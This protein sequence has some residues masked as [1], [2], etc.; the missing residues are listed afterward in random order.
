AKWPANTGATM[1]DGFQQKKNRLDSL[2]SRIA[3]GNA[4]ARATTRDD[5]R[6]CKGCAS[7][8]APNTVGDSC[9]TCSSPAASNSS[10]GPTHSTKKCCPVCGLGVLTVSS[11][12]TCGV[13]RKWI[14]AE[15]DRSIESDPDDYTCAACRQSPI[16]GN[17]AMLGVA[18]VDSPLADAEASNQG[19]IQ[20]GVGSLLG[21]MRS[22]SVAGSIGGE[23]GRFSQRERRMSGS[24]ESSSYS[25]RNS[26]SFDPNA[27]SED[28]DEFR[29][30]SGRGGSSSRGGR[31]GKKKPGGRGGTLMKTRSGGKPPSGVFLDRLGKTERG[32][33]GK[34]RGAGK[35]AG[36]SS[37]KGS[38]AGSRGGGVRRTS[39]SGRGGGV[40]G[41]VSQQVNNM[42]LAAAA[43]GNNQIFTAL[44][45]YQHA[46][47]MQAGKPAKTSDEAPCSSAAIDSGRG[48][49][50]DEYTRTV[51]IEKED[52]GFFSSAPLCL[53]CGSIGVRAEQSM[54]ACS[55]CAHSFH[56]YCVGLHEKMNTTIKDR[57]WRCLD[58]TICEGCGTNTDESKLIMCEECDVAYHMYCLNPPLERAPPGPWR[59]QWCAKC[60][61]CNM[62]VANSGEL[63]KEGLCYPCL[64][65]R[66]C[67]KCNKLYQLNENI[68]RCSQCFKWYHGACEDLHNEEMLENAAL[69]KMRCSTCRP[70]SG[71]GLSSM[72]DGNI[73]ICDNVALNKCADEVLKSKMMPQLF[74]ANS[75]TD[76]AGGTSALAGLLG[77]FRSGGSIDSHYGSMDDDGPDEDGMGGGLSSLINFGPGSRGGRGGGR[78][79]GAGRG[80]LLKMGVG[81]FFVKQ[82]KSKQPVVE[83]NENGEI[84]PN[85]LTKKVKM[86]RKPRRSQL[87][88]FYPSQIQEA[89][90]GIRPVDGK[91]L[92]DIEVP[93]PVME[94]YRAPRTVTDPFQMGFKLSAAATESLRRDIEEN[95]MLDNLNLNEM[96]NPDEDF[97]FD[98]WLDDEDDDL[99][100]A[101]DFMKDDTESSQP[102]PEPD[103]G[104]G[105]QMPPQPGHHQMQQQQH[106]MGMPTGFG[107][108]GG[109]MIKLEPGLM[110]P[111]QMM[112]HPH[113]MMGPGGM[114]IKQEPGM[115]RPESSMSG[116]SLMAAP[117]GAAHAGER[118]S[119][120]QAAT[121]RWEEDEPL[122]DKA[123]K[124]AVLYVNINF[125]NQRRDMPDW[126][127]RAKFI[128]KTWRSLSSDDRQIYVQKA[129]HNR[130]QREKV[131]RPR[132][133]RNPQLGAPGPSGIPTTGQV[134]MR[135]A[136]GAGAMPPGSF[137][138]QAAM[139]NARPPMPP[140]ITQQPPSVSHLP[141][142]LQQQYESMRKA[143]TE[144]N[145]K[146]EALAKELAA[147][148]TTKKKLGAKLR[149]IQ[150]VE[151]AK[152]LAQAVAAAQ[153]AGIEPPTE[154]PQTGAL[155]QMERETY[156]KAI[157]QTPL[158]VKELDDAKRIAKA[159]LQAMHSFEANHRIMS[160]HV[161]AQQ[162][163][164]A[165]SGGS[166]G[167]T[168]GGM[169]SASMGGRPGMGMT[170]AGPHGF[171]QM[172]PPQHVPFSQMMGQ[173]RSFQLGGLGSGGGGGGMMGSRMGP[174]ASSRW[175]PAL[176]RSSVLGSVRYDQIQT[177]E[178]RD[179]YECLDE[180]I[181]KISYDFDGPPPMMQQQQQM[182]GFPGGGNSLKR[183]LD[184]MAPP[185]MGMN[186]MMQGD[187]GAPKQ[188]K[189]RQM[190]KKTTNPREGQDYDTCLQRMKDA[191]AACPPLTRKAI[192][193]VA[194][195]ESSPFNWP[196][197]SELD[198]IPESNC[199]LGKLT[200]PFALD[201]Y[202]N[203]RHVPPPSEVSMA[204]LMP[205][206]RMSLL[207]QMAGA[208]SCSSPCTP[209]LV[210]DEG[211]ISSPSTSHGAANVSNAA[212]AASDVIR[213]LVNGVEKKR[214]VLRCLAKANESSFPPTDPH[215]IA[216][217]ESK[218]EDDEEI[219][220]AIEIEERCAPGPSGMGGESSSAN[221]TSSQACRDEITKDLLQK[222]QKML[223]TKKPIDDYQM[224]TPPQS[225]TGVD[226]HMDVKP[227]PLGFLSHR[228]R[229]CAN[230][231]SGGAIATAYR[232]S[233]SLLGLTP[234][235][236][237]KDDSVT[238]CT[239]KCYYS[240]V[241]NAKVALSPGQLDA[242]QDHVDDLTYSRLKQISADSFAR[243]INQ[244]SM[245]GVKPET[246][247]GVAIA[248]QLGT[249]GAAG[250]VG[251]MGGRGPMAPPGPPPPTPLGGGTPDVT[252]PRENKFG[253]L[254]DDPPP[255][256][257]NIHVI[258]CSDLA[259]LDDSSRKERARAAGEDWK[260]YDQEI[261]NS[262]IRIRMFKNELAMQPKMGIDFAN[263]P[264][265]TRKCALC[266]QKGDTDPTQGGRLLNYD[267]GVWIHAN[268]TLWCPEVYETPNGALL[269]V[270]KALFRANY[271]TCCLC[272]LTGPTLQ[273][274]K[275]ECQ[276]YFHFGCANRIRGKFLKDKTFICPNH[277]DVN[278]D[279]GANIEPLRKL[280]IPRDENKLLTKLFEHVDG[281]RLMLRLGAFTFLRLGQLL[282][283]QLK[284]CHSSRFIF[285]LGYSAHRMYWS[286]F[287][288][289]KRVK[290]SL[291]ITEHEGK[292]LF[293]VS[294]PPLRDEIVGAAIQGQP[295][296]A[297]PH[298]W[299]KASAGEAWKEV[300]DCVNRVRLRSGSFLR[301]PGHS[302]EGES[303]FGLAEGVITKMTESLPGVDTLYSYTFRH[304]GAP[305]LELP[306]AENPSGCARCE[307]RL[308]TLIKSHRRPVPSGAKA[309]SS[310][311][312]RGSKRTPSL[313]EELQMYAKAS[314]YKGD[315]VKNGKWE[316]NGTN[317]Q[318]YSA[319]QKMR[320]EWRNTVY[321]ARSAIQGLGL[322][323]KQDI[324]MD[325]MIIEYKGEV[326]RGEV[327]EMREKKYFAQNRGTYMFKA[328][329]ECIIDAT[330]KGGP[331]RYINHS[332]DPN[333]RTKIMNLGPNGEE[334][335]IIIIAARPIKA[336]EELTYDY[337]FDVED[338]SEKVACLCG[339][340]NCQRW[341]N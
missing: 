148:R 110:H 201:V 206:V 239:L 115:M 326:V 65:L 274:Y 185:L 76:S 242:A 113:A 328:S 190:Q 275:M 108:P 21:S 69:N 286:P 215:R 96:M 177:T 226:H 243:S 269:N 122:G 170:L 27:C 99:N 93:E 32:K 114:M 264:H 88:D 63:T 252:S 123:T 285:P 151:T 92:A 70:N 340:P 248:Q 101:L 104:M 144:Y 256:K 24:S 141:P 199:G 209:L 281:P 61:R 267:V 103:D 125:P 255:R 192:E 299:R 186:S 121:E 152:A 254:M 13:C 174:M 163:A 154:V 250:L 112:Q 245:A 58:C 15:C 145:Q 179:V 223:E 222:L 279:A 296:A 42:L 38:G 90:F 1:D 265:D 229:A 162:A 341:M 232:Q 251:G 62:R 25:A 298:V 272:G 98:D 314:G 30:G 78:G 211:D 97:N 300:L 142:E 246:P 57:G 126:S 311:G 315:Y 168:V 139:G 50:E 225:P 282:P 106:A 213:N 45:Q 20:G 31:G 187:D 202:K 9:S 33:R 294:M 140:G 172:V 302:I 329:D 259:K 153:A 240:F 8:L 5:P 39:T 313:Y 278:P 124:A 54:V 107:P 305:V 105:S 336:N 6:K 310:E 195:N 270:D 119:A 276:K 247:A 79:G 118:V 287:D 53:V 283:E 169:L 301:S 318:S 263:L 217:K 116:G 86:T 191:L 290:F 81:G 205:N 95:S 253:A 273:C 34:G 333:C 111:H 128:H 262:Y 155:N 292:P 91:A 306:L 158:T 85:E 7:E 14:H 197:M 100:D 334:K 309:S 268:C 227:A 224:D 143:A 231:I 109:M 200:L 308:R 307:P 160:E 289:R 74:R 75:F 36:A 332:C 77:E 337:Q 19:S 37:G 56:T 55:G 43:G 257:E 146:E 203:I 249:A 293:S 220:V 327:C 130:A 60:K 236:D 2:S 176:L 321:L 134:A 26:P 147:L 11:F 196:G 149:Q 228:C 208:S 331:A 48:E 181:G 89:F 165:A 83:K 166:A 150:K 64:S 102:K 12:L 4:Q 157:V 173:E 216:F 233:M 183:M 29:P 194:R 271:T 120:S 10:G 325:D 68:I 288:A 214:R 323:A 167:P 3:R 188:K 335:K 161:I 46:Q 28:D 339:A 316:Q 180:M 320:K 277:A 59:C 94:E 80:R 135:M 258:R 66:K 238:F 317:E 133:P 159:H 221:S 164:A 234:S 218:K 330:M 18:A 182:G 324:A 49:K 241:A 295:S 117:V 82:P 137:P 260:K 189:K 312:G 291:S 244:N 84:D 132:G 131:P 207:Y 322:Y 156:D 261:M 284:S 178:E 193:P 127:E 71:R 44:L 16:V 87:E 230:V 198:R 41:G 67:P 210:R 136:A 219:E 319:Y 129:R 22:S 212:G 47:A 235:D 52:D 72:N 73:V 175:G 171:Q 40:V 17:D 280:Y 297:Q 35:S 184:P 338:D 304:G 237:G 266:G 51:V 303:L 138:M 23:S 204:K